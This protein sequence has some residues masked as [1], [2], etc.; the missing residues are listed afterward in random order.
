MGR[1]ILSDAVISWVSYRKKSLIMR[2]LRKGS[3]SA[4]SVIAIRPPPNPHVAAL[5]LNPITLHG[6]AD[7]Y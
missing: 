5:S 4:N 1:V 3:I 2:C 7:K 6:P